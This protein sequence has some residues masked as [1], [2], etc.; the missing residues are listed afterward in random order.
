MSL[1]NGN[2]RSDKVNI[3]SGNKRF[4]IRGNIAG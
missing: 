1:V 2:A 4:S 3:L